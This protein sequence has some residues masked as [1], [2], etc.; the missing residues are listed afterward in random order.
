MAFARNLRLGSGSGRRKK[1]SKGD[2]DEEEAIAM[3]PLVAS[4]IERDC[5][6]DSIESTELNM[7]SKHSFWQSFFTYE[8]PASST[9]SSGSRRFNLNDFPAGFPVNVVRNQKYSLLSFLPII[10][11]GQFRFFFNLYFLLVSLSQLIKVF[12]VGYIISYFG[13]LV[14]VLGITISKEA[15]EDYY[16]FIQDKEANSQTY[17]VVRES[18][19]KTIISADLKVGDLVLIPKNTKFP[20]DCIFMKTDDKTGSCFIRTDQL[21]GETDWKLRL[22]LISINFKLDW[23]YLLLNYFQIINHC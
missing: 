15:Y 10:L 22:I 9:A 5:D 23:L 16:R 19:L 2:V 4:S 14:F 18:G 8:R 11:Y 21:D 13:P 7:A 12:Q 17:Q 1:R 6:S 20:A 3:E